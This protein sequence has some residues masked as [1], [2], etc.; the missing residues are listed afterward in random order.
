VIAVNTFL[1]GIM[2]GLIAYYIQF[3]RTG[4]VDISAT[5]SG[6]IAGLM[7]I[8]APCAYVDSWAAVV[9]GLI[10]GVLVVASAEFMEKALKLDDPVWAVACHGVNGIW[11]LIAVGI[12]ANGEYGDVG[13]LIVG[14]SGQ[15]IA[16][17]ISVV[18]VVAWT[19]VAS[20]VIFGVI[21]ATMGLR[22]DNADEVAGLDASEFTQAGYVFEATA[23]GTPVR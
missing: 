23:V 8:T 12:F 22:V 16:Q 6:I 14:N 3:A 13:G 7:A 5:C 11:G 21:R 17:L 9:I 15:I 19:S 2:G 18:A 1:A 20:F 10:A 4:K